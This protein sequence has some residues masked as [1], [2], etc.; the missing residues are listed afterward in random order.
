MLKMMMIWMTNNE[1]LIYRLTW[2]YEIYLG[3]SLGRNNEMYMG[4]ITK[5]GSN[6]S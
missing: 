3:Q 5:V 2:V 6:E 4:C 1:N